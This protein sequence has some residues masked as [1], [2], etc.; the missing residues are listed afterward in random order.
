MPVPPETASLEGLME[1]EFHNDSSIVFNY[2]DKLYKYNFIL[3]SINYIKFAVYDLKKDSILY[4]KLYFNLYSFT[5]EDLNESK[6][7]YSDFD[8]VL[9]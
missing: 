8:T 7:F 9:Y 6:V 1:F 4:F 2:K 5:K 3:N